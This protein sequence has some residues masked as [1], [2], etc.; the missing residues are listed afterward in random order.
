MWTSL[1]SYLG[2]VITPTEPSA[3]EIR[4]RIAQAKSVTC[5]M[6]NVWRSNELT[7]SLK[8]RLVKSLVWSVALYGCESWTLRQ[9]DEYMLLSFEMGV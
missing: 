5:R 3:C 2:S 1:S 9:C 4:T 6:D 7:L 8:K